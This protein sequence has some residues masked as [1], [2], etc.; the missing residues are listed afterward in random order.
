MQTCANCERA[1]I[2]SRGNL[3]CNLLN[4]TV[5]LPGKCSAHPGRS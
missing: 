4:R 3:H 2:N 1:T 5:P